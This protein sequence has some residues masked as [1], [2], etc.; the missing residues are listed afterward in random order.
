MEISES[1]EIFKP[2]DDTYVFS[3]TKLIL[4]NGSQYF[5]AVAVN[6][7]LGQISEIEISKLQPVAIPGPDIWPPFPTN[8]TRAP[9]PLPKDCYVKRQSLVEYGES[10]EN[11][12]AS[13]LLLHEARICET[14]KKSPHRNIAQYLGCLVDN[15]RVKGLCFTRYGDDLFKMIRDGRSF[16]RLLCL[17]SIRMGIK[18]LHRLGI[19]HCDINPHNIFSDGD[20]FVVG[21]FDS[22]ALEGNELGLK[23]GTLDWTDENFT[24]ANRE[25]DWYGLFKIAEFL[26]PLELS[27]E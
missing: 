5:Y 10:E 20:D 22:C 3:H 27:S 19:V 1:V 7:K 8:L 25:N 21:D 16:N 6:H 18:H 23:G 2:Q 9:E 14:L 17:K 15:G 24:V 11:T 12:D 4:N 26:F 13:I